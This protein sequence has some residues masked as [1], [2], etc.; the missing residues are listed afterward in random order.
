MLKRFQ[1]AKPKPL[2]NPFFTGV[3]RSTASACL[4]DGFLNLEELTAWES[5]VFHTEAVGNLNVLILEA[6]NGARLFGR[7]W[8]NSFELA[9]SFFSIGSI[10]KNVLIIQFLGWILGVLDKKAFDPIELHTKTKKVPK[11]TP[12]APQLVSTFFVLLFG[13]LRS[14]AMIRLIQIADKETTK[15]VA[16]FFFGK[17]S[18]HSTARKQYS[19]IFQWQEVSCTS[20]FSRVKGFKTSNWWLHFKPRKITA[21]FWKPFN[22]T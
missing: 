16:L 1:K 15:P 6:S 19:G 8:E 18:G 21:G 9:W 2:S 13:V 14:K 12:K 17:L 7:R 4:G 11:N 10:A 22:Y 20:C 5:G 3:L